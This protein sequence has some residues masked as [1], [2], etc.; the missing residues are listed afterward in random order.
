MYH[1]HCN[2]PSIILNSQIKDWKSYTIFAV[3]RDPIEKSFSQFNKIKLNHDNYFTDKSRYYENGGTVSKKMRRV[4]NTVKNINSFE[5]YLKYRY[6]FFPYDD[7]ISINSKYITDYIR[8]ENLATDF[9]EIIRKLDLKILRELPLI[10]KT[11]KVGSFK[12][13]NNIPV[14]KYFLPYINAN[15]QILKR[16]NQKKISIFSKFFFKFFSYIR[17]KKIIYMDQKYILQNRGVDLR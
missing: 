16:R 7:N 5:G 17:G 4:H 9:A 1:K 11:K 8:F 3:I 15:K 6:S 2:F 12:N 14:N 13:I 10:N